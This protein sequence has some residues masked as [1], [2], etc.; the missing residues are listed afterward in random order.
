VKDKKIFVAGHRGMVGSAVVDNLKLK[1]YTNI[2]T[3][4][5]QELDLLNQK[6]VDVFFR[7]E[8]IDHVVLCAA[9]VGG[10]LANNTYRADFI[11]DNLQIASNIIKASHDHSVDKLINL[12]SSC[13]YPRDA[14][15]PI[16][17]EYLL[18]GELEYTNEPYAIAKIAALKMCESFYKQYGSDFYSI[19]PCNLYGPRDN[20]DLQTSHVLP[21]LINKIYCAREKGSQSVEVWGSGK[22]LREFLFVDDL[23]E[24]VV[25]CLENVSAGN[26]YSQDISHLNCGS[27]DEVSILQLAQLIKSSLDYQGDIVFDSS[28]PDGTFRKKMDNTRIKSMGFLQ[29]YDLRAGIEKTY[30]WYIKNLEINC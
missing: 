28:K 19:M 12:G 8:S 1:G 30:A 18:T 22:P 25:Y 3:R 9:K 16:K 14:K 11:Y 17:E 23:A 10:I 13:I 7:N 15:I 6:A 27:D 24:A 2:I 20:F 4:T 5:R 29:K 26:V 21:A